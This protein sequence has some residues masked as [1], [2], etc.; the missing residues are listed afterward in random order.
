MNGNNALV[1]IMGKEVSR[2]EYRNEP[3]ITFR[4]MDELHERPEGTAK[5]NFREN[6]HRFIENEDYFEVPYAE[7]IEIL[8][9]QNSSCQDEGNGHGGHRGG[10]IF[11]TQPGYLLLVKSFTDD[12]A[13]Q[14]QRQLTTFYFAVRDNRFSPSSPSQ[15]P[16]Y[17]QSADNELKM[18]NVIHKQ[19]DAASKAAERIVNKQAR[20]ED[21]DCVP[22]TRKMIEKTVADMQ[23]NESEDSLTALEMAKEGASMS[24]IARRLWGSSGGNQVKKLRSMLSRHGMVTYGMKAGNA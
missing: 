23:E 14:V 8:T 22:I 3:V 12:L 21:Y 2:I 20:M 7:W 16:D 9:I 4:M 10:M 24:A 17:L 11:I 1:K 13:W 18:L 19:Q 5:R 6:R 15:W